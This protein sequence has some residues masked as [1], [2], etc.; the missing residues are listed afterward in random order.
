MPELPP[1]G[2]P[3]R[4]TAHSLSAAALDDVHRRGRGGVACHPHRFHPGVARHWPG[5]PRPASELACAVCHHEHQGKDATLARHGRPAVP[6]VSHDAVSQF[7][8]R[9]PRVR[10]LPLSPA[11]RPGLQ[12]RL[13]P[14]P[15][16]SRVSPHHAGGQSA[17]VVPGLPRAK[18][19]RPD[20]ARATIST[21]LR[22]LSP[23][24][25]RGLV[26]GRHCLPES[27]GSGRHDAPQTPR[28]RRGR[29]M[30]GVRQRR[31]ESLHAAA[32]LDGRSLRPGGD[33]RCTGRSIC[34]TSAGE[35]RAA[36]RRWIRYVWAI[37]DLLHGLSQDDEA[38]ALS[39]RLEKVLASASRTSA[40]SRP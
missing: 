33:G 11:N 39:R 13:P 12:P 36:A 20:D 40:N 15:A 32:P 1:D 5:Q 7:R 4:S 21:N 38:M 27:P 29:R 3:W 19:R 35:R 17:H 22:Q 9:P 24:A 31:S 18:P 37:K 14:G 10:R 26:S 34:A 30:A 6:S 16:L 28:N 2:G 23:V 8:R 25:D